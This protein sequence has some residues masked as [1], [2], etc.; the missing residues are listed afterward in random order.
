MRLRDATS[1]TAFGHVPEVRVLLPEL[2]CPQRATLQTWV[3]ESVL[4]GL[5]H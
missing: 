5:H 4:L 3:L 1:K 2:N